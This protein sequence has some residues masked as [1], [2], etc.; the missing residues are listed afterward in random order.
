MSA[1]TVIPGG[2]GK[3]P[4]RVLASRADLVEPWI[5]L[6]AIADEHSE[7]LVEAVICLRSIQTA[8][9]RGRHGLVGTYA[10]HLESRITRA[11]A[12]LTAASAT[13]RLRLADLE[14]CPDAV[15]DVPG[16][17]VAA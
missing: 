9:A 2:R 17:G 5:E 8:I 12:R 6:A 4:G 16:H 13:A 14:R 11:A 3:G 7:L 1:L 10:D 15:G